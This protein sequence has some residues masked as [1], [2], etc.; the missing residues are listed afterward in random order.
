MNVLIIR[1]SALGDVIL[2][3]PVV[4][5]L[6]QQNHHVN[7]W[8][9]SNE[10]YQELYNFSER[11][12]F[13]GLDTKGKHKSINSIISLVDKMDQ[14]HNFDRIYDLHDVIRSKII[15]GF[16]KIKKKTIHTLNKGRK[17][18]RKLIDHKIPFEKLPHTIERYVDCLSIDFKE[19][20]G[21]EINKVFH[22]NEK[23]DDNLIGIAPFAAHESKMWP[24]KNYATIIRYFSSKSFIIFAF[25][26]KE[27]ELAKKH[28]Y[29]FDNCRIIEQDKTITQQIQIINKLQLIISMD[30]ANMHL[31]SL[32]KTPVISIWGP[33]HHYTGF[34]PLFNS[35]HIIEVSRDQLPCRPCSVYGKIKRKDLK[36]ATLSME[37]IQ[38]ETVINKMSD[39]LSKSPLQ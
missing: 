16:F 1:L 23:Q 20:K 14:I 28:F 25:G 24:L 35:E 8:I 26:E 38:P 27:V 33:T 6:I 36:C 2:L 7:V 21:K 13:I 5:L 22:S 3:R 12:K 18:K 32:T 37:L 9:L 11:V 19:L 17:Q 10:K 34:G 15:K 30:S 4:E 29:E 39:I 31:S